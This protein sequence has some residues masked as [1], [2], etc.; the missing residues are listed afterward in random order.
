MA[1]CGTMKGMNVSAILLVVLLS[2][3]TA[4]AAPGDSA[5]AIFENRCLNCHGEAQ[6]SGLDLRQIG[7]ITKGGKRGPA[8]VPGHADQSLLYKAVARLG[9]LQMPPGKPL[10]AEEVATI[11]AWIDG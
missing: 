11:R 2:A 6:T 10:P 8:I 3:L 4:M 5:R 9:D 1:L 7:A